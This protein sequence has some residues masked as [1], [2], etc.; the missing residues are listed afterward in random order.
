MTKDDL[1][2]SKIK[3]LLEF[4]KEDFP[5]LHQAAENESIILFL[6]AGVSKLYGCCLWK[7]NPLF[8]ILIIF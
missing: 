6:G 1:S 7:E 3:K 8:E 2:I 5:D 4:Q